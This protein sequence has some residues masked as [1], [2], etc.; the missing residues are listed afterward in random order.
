MDEDDDYSDEKQLAR[1]RELIADKE[2]QHFPEKTGAG[3]MKLLEVRNLV[4]QLAPRLSIG[5]QQLRDTP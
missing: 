4:T 5:D 2:L 3:I 1:L